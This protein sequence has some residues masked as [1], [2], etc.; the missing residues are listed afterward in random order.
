M[1]LRSFILNPFH[2][3]KDLTSK[4]D[5]VEI[6]ATTLGS[7]MLGGSFAKDFLTNG[8][9]EFR[10]FLFGFSSFIL[11]L[12]ISFVAQIRI[13][14]FQSTKKMISLL[15][16]FFFIVGT[17]AA[18]DLFRSQFMINVSGFNIRGETLAFL[19][20]YTVSTNLLYLLNR[21]ILQ[22]TLKKKT[23]YKY[24]LAPLN[25]LSL[26]IVSM[27]AMVWLLG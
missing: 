13:S 18:I 9:F 22:K 12:A 17:L 25:G 15:W 4:D 23:I 26:G 20:T 19:T 24:L 27:G 14:F 11:L 21:E 16:I 7:F 6:L 3:F 2:A 1:V 8:R 10:I 5:R